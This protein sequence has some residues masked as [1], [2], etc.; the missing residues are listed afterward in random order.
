MSKMELK[1]YILTKKP[2]FKCRFCQLGALFAAQ[3]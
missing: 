1:G 2:L 3:K